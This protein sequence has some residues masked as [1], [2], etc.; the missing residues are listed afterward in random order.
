MFALRNTT[1]AIGGYQEAAVNMKEEGFV[2][3]LQTDK[4]H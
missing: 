2:S 4:H 3:L 1:Y